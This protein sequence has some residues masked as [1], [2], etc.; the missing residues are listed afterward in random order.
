MFFQPYKTISVKGWQYGD[1]G[2]VN[3]IRSHQFDKEWCFRVVGGLVDGYPT[4]FS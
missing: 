3:M 2:F 4:G 1:D